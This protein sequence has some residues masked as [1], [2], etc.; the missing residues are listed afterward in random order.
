M[1]FGLF[2]ILAV[3]GGGF[4]AHFVASD[5]GYV[6]IEFSGYLIETSVPV[7]IALV[8]A[9]G[10][11]VWSIVWLFRTPRRLGEAYG[12]MRRE[13]QTKQFTRGLIA[14]AEGRFAKGERLLTRGAGDAETPMLNYLAAARVAH[15]QGAIERRD[16]WLTLAYEQTPDAGNAVLL[17]Q[18]ELQLAQGQYEQALATLARVRQAVPNHPQALTLLARTYAALGDWAALGQYLPTL[19]KLGRFDEATLSDWSRRAAL[20]RFENSAGDKA[21]LTSAWRALDKTQQADPELL[22]VY[23]ERLIDVGASKESETLL[24]KALSKSWDDTLV[25]GYGE[26]TDA[27][28]A[29]QLKVVEGWLRDRGDNAALL[30]AAGRICI[31]GALWGKARSYLESAIAIAPTPAMYQAYGELLTALGE[32]DP[33]S[34]AF[35]QGLGMAAGRAPLTLPAPDPAAEDESATES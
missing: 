9:I 30:Y 10:I 13:R 1:K 28:P 17:T 15:Q 27:A 34:A 25:T 12:A 24:R 6:V 33:A 26:L 20:T 32:A 21:A 35:R 23:V 7:L 16:N 4:F 8:A 19:S 5:P 3:I 22:L 2:V 14:A 18:A 31:R 29:S 11:A